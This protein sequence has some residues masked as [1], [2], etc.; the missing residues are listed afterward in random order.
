MTPTLQQYVDD[1]QAIVRETERAILL[2]RGVTAKQAARAQGF[3]RISDL[4]QPEDLRR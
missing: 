4:A 1:V 3:R 2:A